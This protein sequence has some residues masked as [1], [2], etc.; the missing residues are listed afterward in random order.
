MNTWSVLVRCLIGYMYRL[1]G[2][3]E[4]L[5]TYQVLCRFDSYLRASTV[6]LTVDIHVQIDM[7]VYSLGSVNDCFEAAT[8]ALHQQ[9]MARSAVNMMSTPQAYYCAASG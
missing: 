9:L 7:D 2:C 4:V 3:P 1:A 8:A 5:G 6:H